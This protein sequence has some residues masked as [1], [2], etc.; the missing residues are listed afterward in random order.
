MRALL[1]HLLEVRARDVAEILATTGR[2]P[3]EHYAELVAAHGD[4]AYARVDAPADRAQKAKLAALSPSDVSATE[5]FT[6]PMSIF[7][8]VLGVCERLGITA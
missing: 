7:D 1:V 8:E 5:P 4:P 2:T 3:S 6:I